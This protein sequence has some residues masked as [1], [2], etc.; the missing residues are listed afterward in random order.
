MSI[1]A[2][3]DIS[4]LIEH[5]PEPHR[6]A[7]SVI[8]A[9]KTIGT[10]GETARVGNVA[11]LS[12]VMVT[13]AALVAVE[14]GTLDLDEPAGPPGSTA[15]HLL[16]HASGLAF[17]DNSSIAR[18]GTRRIYSNAGIEQ[19]A[20]LLEQR[21]AFSI[22]E[23][24]QEAVFGPL[25]MRNTSLTGSP[26]TDVES[27]VDDLTL[28]A[29]ELLTPTLLAEATLAE[30]TTPQFR[31]L[32]GVLPGFGSFDPNFWGLGFELKGDKSPHWLAPDSPPT[33]FGHFGVSG[34]YLWVDATSDLACVA[35]AGVPYGK[36]A[37]EA[38]PLTN[39][40]ITQRFGDRS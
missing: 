34:A 40:A 38:W 8:G 19:L 32:R 13:V 1:T 20:K 2:A 25:S 3:D 18:P 10:T 5:W 7:L 11:S 33:T 23:Y 37:N 35:M 30:A 17:D 29:H 28:L 31:D 36:W 14:D 24:L 9:G 21:T 6:A 4:D 12:K 27:S 26:A 16:A 15:R 22:A 39:Q